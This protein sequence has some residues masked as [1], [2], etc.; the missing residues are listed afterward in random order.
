ML[1]EDWPRLQNN[2]KEGNVTLKILPYS[3]SEVPQSATESSLCDLLKGSSPLANS[4]V[5]TSLL[6][7][8]IKLFQWLQSW[9]SAS[10]I[11]VGEMAL[12]LG[13]LHLPKP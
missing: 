4:A 5:C 6:T 9:Q 13:R 12:A 7:A 2:F 3:V 11:G 8:H 10:L 1:S